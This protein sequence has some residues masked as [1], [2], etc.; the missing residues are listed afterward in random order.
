M[1]F[2]NPTPQAASTGTASYTWATKP[3]AS[4]VP[5]GTQIRASDVGV[6]S[7][8]SIWYSDGSDWRPLGGSVI[9]KQLAGNIASPAVSFT[10]ST[11]EQQLVMPGGNVRIPAGML[12]A[13]GILNISTMER[14]VIVGGSTN[15]A[16]KMRISTGGLVFNG[17]SVIDSSLTPNNCYAGD[18]RVSVAGAN[19]LCTT[20]YNIRNAFASGSFSD[21]GNQINISADMFLTIDVKGNNVG[22]L[23]QLIALSV[24][25][26]Q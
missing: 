26:E 21:L 11:T 14:T 8:G 12:L 10:G 5:V 18:V 2:D 6:G 24:K 19:S 13:G 23:Y 17:S 16:R 3:A 22:D 4:A 9:L 7:G 15:F 25:L 1:R 20:N